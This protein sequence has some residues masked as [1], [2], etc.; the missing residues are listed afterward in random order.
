M[1]TGVL[2]ADN[3]EYSFWQIDCRSLRA[4]SDFLLGV[5]PDVILYEDFKHRP[6]LMKAELYSVQ[7]I[8]VTRLYAEI[9][10]IDIPFTPI[11]AEAKVFWTDDKIKKLGMWRPGMPHAMDAL[12]VYLTY[13]QK[14]DIAWFT[15]MLKLLR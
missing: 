10:D 15:N 12:R 5:K 1:T 8:G 3:A 7:V 9:H 4:W 13:K 11:P 6:N 2:I 14:T